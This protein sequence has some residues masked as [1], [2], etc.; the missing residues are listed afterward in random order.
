MRV[1]TLLGVTAL[2]LGLGACNAS[3]T[4]DADDAPA[5]DVQVHD[6]EYAGDTLRATGDAVVISLEQDGKTRRAHK[7]AAVERM[8][9]EDGAERIGF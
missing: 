6:G 3:V 9:G 4:H 1:S 2:A 8:L 7:P 5:L